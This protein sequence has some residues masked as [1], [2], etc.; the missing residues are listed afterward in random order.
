VIEGPFFARISSLD[1]A[2]GTSSMRR[3][4]RE[5]LYATAPPIQKGYR[6]VVAMIHMM[7]ASCCIGVGLREEDNV[8]SASFGNLLVIV[9]FTELVQA[10]LCVYLVLRDIG[11]EGEHARTCILLIDVR[12][13]P[14]RPSSRTSIGPH[15]EQ[16]IHPAT[17]RIARA[18]HLHAA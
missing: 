18:M 12:Q 9:G 8:C 17:P 4:Q 6:S 2:R 1:S 14:I 10:G 15:M 16:S 13:T 3:E 7:V 5:Q 11:I